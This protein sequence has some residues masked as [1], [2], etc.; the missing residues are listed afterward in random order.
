MKQLKEE[1]QRQPQERKGKMDEQAQEQ[2][3]KREEEAAVRA[4]E[5][6]Q[7]REGTEFQQK[8]R[9]RV[10]ENRKKEL[11]DKLEQDSTQQAMNTAKPTSNHPENLCDDGILPA[12]TQAEQDRR[13][14]EPRS[15]V[16]AG[17][18]APSQGSTP[19]GVVPGQHQRQDPP[20]VQHDALPQPIS[21]LDEGQFDAD[22]KWR[23]DD[24][25][26][27]EPDD[28]LLASSEAKAQKMASNEAKET[29]EVNE[30]KPESL[31]SEAPPN[32]S[33]NHLGL[34]TGQTDTRQHPKEINRERWEQDVAAAQ[35]A[36]EKKRED[37][38]QQ[39]R[40]QRECAAAEERE[41]VKKLL[42]DAATREER[43]LKEKERKMNEREALA[44][45]AQEKQ[46]LDLLKKEMAQAELESARQ[47]EQELAHAQEQL[48]HAARSQ[49]DNDAH[50]EHAEPTRK[51]E[52]KAK[53]PKKTRHSREAELKNELEIAAAGGDGT[54]SDDEGC[55]SKVS[56]WLKASS[57]GGAG[58]EA[59]SV[60]R[61]QSDQPLCEA[62][63]ST[64]ESKSQEEDRKRRD[65][66]G[67]NEAAQVDKVRDGVKDKEG[68][69]NLSMWQMARHGKVQQ[70]E[71]LMMQEGDA[72][73]PD[74]RDPKGN[75]LL[76]HACMHGK[77]R[78][79]K[80]VLRRGADLNAQNKQ[81]DCLPERWGVAS[82]ALTN[83]RAYSGNTCLHYCF[84]Y[85][86][87]EL[88]MIDISLALPAFPL[89]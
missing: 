9:Q 38:E 61:H 44:R 3:C 20:S 73:D 37:R 50:Q 72:F 71:A 36:R 31:A 52:K 69:R 41:K 58:A 74:V 6:Q 53:K 63:Q 39:D 23:S 48:A 55:D 86:Y 45:Q 78:V 25:P 76:H 68:G 79:A 83:Q 13:Q 64:H 40:T 27:R 84:A 75:T 26:V 34:V 14:D 12:A 59:P 4:R 46:M 77:K 28:A 1:V 62:G 56:D 43:L 88:G 15:G 16:L 17:A 32:P 54:V 66:G 18:V 89:A 30:N 87:S 85:G 19:L 70:L 29:Q 47:R 35:A 21:S 11:L 24:D 49:S 82:A 81:G 67:G 2:E 60:S 51:R 65:D 10:R 57:A 5:E 22:V 7:Q 8:E 42:Q 80:A 33:S